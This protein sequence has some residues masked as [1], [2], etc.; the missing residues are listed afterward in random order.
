MTSKAPNDECALDS[1][2]DIE[3]ELDLLAENG[4]SRRKLLKGS[5]RD[6][7]ATASSDTKGAARWLRKGLLR[8]ERPRR[9]LREQ[10]NCKAKSG[11]LVHH[12]VR[13][14]PEGLAELSADYV[15]LELHSPAV[16]ATK[17]IDGTWKFPE[18]TAVK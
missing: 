18:A 9:L 14:Q 10:S 3:D 13:R 7:F 12:P 2:E 17:V 16:S 4:E 5:K 15:G 6:G 11:R 1:I 8:E